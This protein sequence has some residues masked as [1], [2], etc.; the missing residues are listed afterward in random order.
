MARGCCSARSRRRRCRRSIL[1]PVLA[2]LLHRPGLA[3]RRQTRLRSALCAWAGASASASSSPGSIGSRR[4]CSSISRNSGGWCPSPSSGVPA[5]LAIF[6]GAARSRPATPPAA[7]CG[8]AAPQ[9]ILALALV[10]GRRRMAARPYPHRLSLEPDRLRLVGR[11][12]RRAR[13]AADRIGG[14]HL[15]AEPA[16]RARRR[17]AGAARRFLRPPLGRRSRRR[18]SIVVPAALGRLAPGA[19]PSRADVARRDLAPGSALD[20]ADAQ[21]RSGRSCVANFRRL[22]ALS[23][24]PGADGADGDHLAR[25]RRRRRFSIAMAAR[26]KRWRKLR[27]RRLCS[28]PGTMRTDPPAAS[29]RRMCGTACVAHRSRRARFVATYDKFHLVPF[30]EYVPLRG[31]LPMQKITPGTIDF[32]AGPGPRTIDVA[33]P[34]A[35]QSA[36]LLRGDFSRCGDRSGASSGLA[37]QHHQ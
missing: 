35:V 16:H 6:T 31:I 28:S 7:G 37:A 30:G 23:T 9:R 33:G 4:R 3:D 14:R 27:R 13:D 11:I 19:R 21:E 18:S 5:G 26:A 25:R 36:D 12:S 32:S 10:L 34:A 1:T 17:V 29:R 24:S 20:P 8:S 2:D 15:R 22:F